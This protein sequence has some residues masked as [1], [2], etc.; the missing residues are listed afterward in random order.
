MKKNF[1]FLAEY[2]SLWGRSRFPVGN[3]EGG[4]ALFSSLRHT[5]STHSQIRTFDRRQS[6]A[7]KEVYN[8]QSIQI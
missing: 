7:T 5:Q 4:Y 1:G 8:A 2:W 3:V 6:A